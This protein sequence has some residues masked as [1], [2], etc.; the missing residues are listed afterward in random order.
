MRHNRWT[1]EMDAMLIK[2]RNEGRRS[3][4]I[5][6]A[7]SEITGVVVTRNAVIGRASRLGLLAVD[8]V[9]KDGALKSKYKRTKHSPIKTKEKPNDPLEGSAP[10]RLFELKQDACRWPLELSGGFF[11]C[12]EPKV[13]GACSYCETHKRMSVR[14]AA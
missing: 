1:P 4:G 13:K 8:L 11:Y 6:A 2:L 10:V 7:L 12:G 3:V 14:R 5:A 9:V